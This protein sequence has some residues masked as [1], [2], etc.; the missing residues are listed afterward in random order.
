M[1]RYKEFEKEAKFWLVELEN[2]NEGPFSALTPN[3]EWTMGQL[4]EHLFQYTV[5]C[6]EKIE[7]SITVSSEG[8]AKLTFAGK[9]VFSLGSFFGKKAKDS[10]MII[11][12]LPS[13]P[14]D[15]MDARNK[16]IRCL[17][18]MDEANDLI[19]LHS[20]TAKESVS[21]HPVFGSLSAIQWF[22]LIIRHFKHHRKQK[23]KIDN[24]FIRS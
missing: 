4:Y 5:Y 24:Y 1:G 23:R 22:D 3:S 10:K 11:P 9:M 20:D 21:E 12:D 13:Q 8:V 17:K 2:Y 7:E 18:L 15:I 19:N 16:I 6:T 14:E